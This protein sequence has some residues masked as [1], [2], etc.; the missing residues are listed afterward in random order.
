MAVLGV[1]A[2]APYGALWSA[3]DVIGCAIDLDEGTVSFMRNGCDLGVAFTD[4]RRL[5]AYFP[6]VSLSYGAR[7]GRC[8]R[9]DTPPE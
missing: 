2:G 8:R 5:Q 7:H 1:V 3:G 9:V 4:V 6:A